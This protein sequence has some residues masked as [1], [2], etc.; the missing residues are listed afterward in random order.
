M[1]NTSIQSILRTLGEQVPPESRLVLVGGSALALL[2]SPRPAI[3]I[4]FVGDDVHPSEIHKT[5]MRVAQE[6]KIFVEPVPLNNSSHCRRGV[7]YATF[8]S[9]NSATWKYLELI[10]TA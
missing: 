5:I 6:L 1:D 7:R 10:R 4:D 8:A 9:G 2:G 3:D